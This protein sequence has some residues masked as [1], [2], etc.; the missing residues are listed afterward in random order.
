M[1][2]FAWDT[3]VVPVVARTPRFWLANASGLTWID[4]RHV[5]FSEITKGL[6][7]RVVSADDRRDQVRAVYSP[8]GERGMAHRSYPSP[9]GAWA[10]VAEMVQP[11]WQPC[12]LVAMSG[13]T[14]RPVGPPGQCTNAAW[15]PDGKWMYFSSNSSGS[16]HIWRQRF[17]DGT[18]EQ[19][20]FGPG[21]EEGVAV[22]PDGR[23]L[24][25]SIG[26]RQSSMW[27]RDSSGEREVSRE[28][29]AFVPSIPNSSMSQP[30]SPDGR[31]LLYLVRQGAVQFAGPG[32]RAGELWRTNLETSQSE[33]LFPGMRVSGYDVSRDGT[34]IV[35]AA[36]DDR[37]ASHLWLGRMDRRVPPHQLSTAQADSPRFRAGGHIY[38]RGS[39]GGES[40]IYRIT[41]GGEPQKVVT[42]PV[43]FFLSVSPDEAWVVARVEA[44]PGANS[45]QENLAFPTPSGGAPVQLC[46]AACEVDWTPNGS[47]LVVK[48]GDTESRLLARTLVV[49][50]HPGE[51]L[52]RFPPHGIRSEADLA[53]LRILQ[54]AD[55]S[56]YPANVPPLVVLVRSTTERNIYRIPLF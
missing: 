5:L 56:V 14:S 6:H 38:Y 37:G 12:R 23:S 35:F 49:A 10:L 33:A 25:T 17:P 52:P 45:S 53:D 4:N 41:A 55:G 48:L 46:P 31:S 16:F 44:A 26:N 30:L 1:S 11:V 18:P 20:S 9:D 21:E 34:Q 28:G 7:M 19:I 24:L 22:S 51:T 54:V 3:W 15:S 8:D 42:R 43:L 29:Y 13:R 36:L 27:V 50:L 32:E 40:F 47:S 2:D 39:E